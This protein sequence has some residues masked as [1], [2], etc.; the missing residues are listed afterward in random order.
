MD[1]YL[2]DSGQL[3]HVAQHMKNPETREREFRAIEADI[4]HIKVKNVLILSESNEER[5]V[6]GGVPV[7]T[8]SIAEWLLT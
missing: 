8:C 4:P 3:I 6:V 5:R 2:P 7:E 1:F